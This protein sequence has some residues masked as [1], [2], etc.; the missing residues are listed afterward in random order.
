MNGDFLSMSPSQAYERI[1]NLNAKKE[2]E[3]LTD[4]EIDELDELTDQFS[5][6][7]FDFDGIDY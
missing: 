6:T 7:A 4:E 2:Y 3:K 5:D 1:S